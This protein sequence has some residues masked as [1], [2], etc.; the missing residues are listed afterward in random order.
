MIKPEEIFEP[1]ILTPA[2]VGAVVRELREQ[3]KW[4]QSTLA[5]LSRLTDRTIQRVENGE[6]SSLDTRRALASAFGFEDIDIF[7]KPVPVPNAE[8]LKAF[9][10]ELEKTT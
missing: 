2:E 7:E 3:H 8:K 1:R 4:S 5:E 6:P 9:T 10:A